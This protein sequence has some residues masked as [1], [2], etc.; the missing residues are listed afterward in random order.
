MSS[1]IGW[2]SAVSC[3]GSLSG[4]AL[5][6][7]YAGKEGV[8][9]LKKDSEGAGVS[10]GLANAA[11]EV[12]AAAAAGYINYQSQQGLRGRSGFACR[13][14]SSLR[15]IESTTRLTSLSF[16]QDLNRQ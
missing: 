14:E 3:L 8:H 16:G 7:T 12:V 1:L 6:S 15:R 9:L 11:A 2:R 4:V 10:C 13:I 5:A